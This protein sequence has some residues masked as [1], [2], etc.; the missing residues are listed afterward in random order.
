MVDRVEWLRLYAQFLAVEQ[1]LHQALPLVT[2]QLGG[3]AL[4]VGLKDVDFDRTS[5][6]IEVMRQRWVRFQEFAEH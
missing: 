6:L 1:E 2:E 4:A 3:A 5:A